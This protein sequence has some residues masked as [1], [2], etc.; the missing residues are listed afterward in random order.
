M[1]ISMLQQLLFLFYDMSDDTNLWCRHDSGNA[2]GTDMA[3][4]RKDFALY[5]IGQLRLDS[6]NL[7]KTLLYFRAY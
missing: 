1:V 7:R 2:S 4:V 5:V 6:P 3:M